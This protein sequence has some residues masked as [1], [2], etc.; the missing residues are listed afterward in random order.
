[1]RGQWNLHWFVCLV[2]KCVEVQKPSC[3]K[4]FMLS[5]TTSCSPLL[6]IQGKNP[7]N[8]RLPTGSV[9][10]VNYKLRVEDAF[11]RSPTSVMLVSSS[12]EISKEKISEHLTTSHF[13]EGFYE[14]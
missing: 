9:F 12:M 7:G 6:I 5:L 4:L 11:Q 13:E 3:Q 14:V 8:M 1:M 10:G 2:L